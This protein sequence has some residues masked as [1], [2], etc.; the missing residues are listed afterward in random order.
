MN[1]LKKIDEYIT[2]EEEFI[3]TLKKVIILPWVS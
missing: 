1:I 2:N 3:R